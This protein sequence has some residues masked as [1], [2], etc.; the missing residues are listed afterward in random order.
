MTV[1][2][3]VSSLGSLN[4]NFQSFWELDDCQ[5]SQP[6]LTLERICCVKNYQSTAMLATNGNNIVKYSLEEDVLN[7]GDGKSTAIK[8][9]FP[10]ENGLDKNP[11]LYNDYKDFML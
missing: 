9:F 5:A 7:L 6:T 1:A 3:F 10:L 4:S 11:K 2:Y 8:N